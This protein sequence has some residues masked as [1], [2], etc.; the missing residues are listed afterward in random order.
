MNK[1]LS[2]IKPRERDTLSAM[3][4]TQRT[5]QIATKLDDPHQALEAFNQ[6]LSLKS[7][8]LI[9]LHQLEAQRQ[10]DQLLKLSQAEQIALERTVNNQDKLYTILIQKQDQQLQELLEIQQCEIER[11]IHK[12]DQKVPQKVQ[13]RE[14]LILIREYQIL[15]KLKKF[16]AAINV[17]ELACKAEQRHL[18]VLNQQFNEMRQKQIKYYDHIH[19]KQQQILKMQFQTQLKDF[20]KSRNQDIFETVQNMKNSKIDMQNAHTLEFV[21]NKLRCVDTE[22]VNGR[23]GQVYNSTFRGSQKLVESL[24]GMM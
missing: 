3:T 17:K 22:I 9:D 18:D 21:N 19:V 5:M 7:S 13:N 11:L 12:I 23:R 14:Y 16:E 10:H 2:Q 20:E 24:R 4:S 15:M 6:T 8:H 1:T